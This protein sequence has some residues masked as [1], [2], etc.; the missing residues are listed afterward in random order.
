MIFHSVVWNA[1]K[2]NAEYSV[3]LRTGSLAFTMSKGLKLKED[4]WLYRT[5]C[6]NE[7]HIFFNDI[8]SFAP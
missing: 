3:S 8:D 1:L 5:E 2:A 4:V 7:R 6:L